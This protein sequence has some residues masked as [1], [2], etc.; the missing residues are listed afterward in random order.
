MPRFHPTKRIELLSPR[1]FANFGPQLPLSGR[2]LVADVVD[3]ARNPGA[4][5]RGQSR[6]RQPGFMV[7]GHRPQP[8]PRQ[9]VE[10]V[11]MHQVVPSLLCDPARR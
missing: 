3:L 5:G 11:P 1:D 4:F 8:L 6:R 10:R 7:G 2:E 9:Q